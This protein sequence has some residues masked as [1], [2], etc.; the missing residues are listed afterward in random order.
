V[1]L[2]LYLREGK[3]QPP[4]QQHPE[5]RELLTL[6]DIQK[7][8]HQFIEAEREQREVRTRAKSN[9][10][11][12]EWPMMDESFRTQKNKPPPPPKKKM[13]DKR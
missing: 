3:V 8:F 4:S 12:R 5:R 7:S 1:L 6:F 2:L 11:C 13:R 9:N 10:G